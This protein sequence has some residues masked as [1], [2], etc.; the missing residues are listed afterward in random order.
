M[1]ANMP[2]D[3]FLATLIN[4]IGMN[5]GYLSEDFKFK[6][7]EFGELPPQ[8]KGQRANYTHM[9]NDT[10]YMEKLLDEL[11]LIIIR[12]F[13]VQLQG[14]CDIDQKGEIRRFL[15][16]HLAID[17]RPWSKLNN[18]WRNLTWSRNEISIAEEMLKEVADT[19][20]IKGAKQY[21]LKK[22][23]I[24]EW[25]RYYHNYDNADQSKA[26]EAISI[27]AKTEPENVKISI[28][29]AKDN[30]K[31]NAR[32]SAVVNL[33]DCNL[34]RELIV[35]TLK[36]R[37]TQ[38]VVDKCVYL[39]SLAILYNRSKWIIES[40]LLDILTTVSEDFDIPAL[41]WIKAKLDMADADDTEK[42]TNE[43]NDRK[44]RAMSMRQKL[45]EKMQNMQNAV[46]SKNPDYFPK[47]KSQTSLLMESSDSESDSVDDFKL[48]PEPPVRYRI[49]K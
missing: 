20:I 47:D 49:E 40:K 23:L 30:Y 5:N 38:S 42:R 1:A 24:S 28:S 33:I 26:F 9:A 12:I 41:K 10:G 36:H 17:Y 35:R 11:Y 4:A 21:G 15:I 3:D 2:P 48:A 16:H 31:L 8:I 39:I 34:M 45:M 44:R 32:I 27:M 22:G 14:T 37:P 43:Q 25:D 6:A 18:T 46:I 7:D 29:L 13:N 19:R